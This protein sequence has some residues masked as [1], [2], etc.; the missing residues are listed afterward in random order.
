MNTKFKILFYFIT[1]MAVCKITSGQNKGF[2]IK[3]KIAGL[4]S[5]SVY[6]YSTLTN[7]MVATTVSNGS[8]TFTGHLDYPEMFQIY[9]NSHMDVFTNLFLENSIIKVTGFIDSVSKI[10]VEGSKSDIEFQE[11]RK[12][13]KTLREQAHA[14]DDALTDAQNK[15]DDSSADSIQLKFDSVSHLILEKV[16][17]YAKTNPTS[18][19]IPNLVANASLNAPDAALIEKIFHEM[20]QSLLKNPRVSETYKMLNDLKKTAVGIIA[21]DFE[22]K[23][24]DEKIIKLSAY[25]GKIVLLDFWASWCQP[26]VQKFPELMQ[27]YKD[28]NSSNFEIIGFSIDKN[29]DA[30]KK[31]LA[32]YQLPWPQLVDFAGPDGA[33]PK[34]YSIIFLPTNFLI[35]KEGKIAAK[36]IYGKK[37]ADKIKELNKGY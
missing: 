23:S 22:L 5:D 4:K 18:V 11:Y 2:V 31:A 33:T 9:Y 7:K 1:L 24:S 10:K 37:L 15:N 19:L 25:K 28:Y 32:K 30:W 34:N 20:D 16:Y 17:G 3:G 26:C 13:F 6:L 27:F 29:E 14:L 8:F 36:N 35:D 21:T 12:S